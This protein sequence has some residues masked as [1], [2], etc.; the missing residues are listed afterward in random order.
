MCPMRPL[1][2]PQLSGDQRIRHHLS[3]AWST[4]QPESMLVN[5]RA[6][7]KIRIA[8]IQPDNLAGNQ[9]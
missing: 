9:G 3:G 5:R 2:L 8:M 1:Q 7:G 6:I 4:W